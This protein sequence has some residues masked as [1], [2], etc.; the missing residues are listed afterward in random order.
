MLAVILIPG[1]NTLFGTSPLSLVEWGISIG[2]SLL[3]IPFVEI[4]KAIERKI[5]SKK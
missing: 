1:V 4:Q 2:I 5:D 3:I